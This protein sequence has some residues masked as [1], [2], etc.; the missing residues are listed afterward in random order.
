MPRRVL[1]GVVVSDKNNKTVLV[2]VEK[3]V[4]HPL[5]KKYVKRHKKYAAHDESNECKI[6]DT[7]K[8]IESKP[9][10]K[11]KKWVVDVKVGA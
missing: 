7:V 4:L 6:G 3:K 11:T 1:Q 2:R 9:I 10:S 8:I 5:Y